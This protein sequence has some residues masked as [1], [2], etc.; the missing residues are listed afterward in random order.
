MIT[1][2]ARDAS[3]WSVVM[4]SKTFRNTRL[5]FV[6][7]VATYGVAQSRLD[8]PEVPPPATSAT[9]SPASTLAEPNNRAAPDL[10]LGSG[11]LVDVN[12]YGMPDFKTEVRINSAGQITLPML[13]A[14]A[15]GG[16]SV[17]K[18]EAMIAQQLKQK[19]LFNDPH[20]TILVKDYATQGIT[21]LGEVQ[22]PGIYPLLGPRSLSDAISTAGGTTPKAGREVVITHRNDPQHSVRVTLPSG[23]SDSAQQNTAIR[24]GDTILVSRAG[25]VYVVGDVHLPGGFVME[26]GKDLTVLQAIALAQGTNPN[27]ALNAARLIR[28]TPEGPKEIPLS[29]KKILSAKAPDMPLQADDIVFVPGSAGKSAAKRGAEAILNMATGVAV[30]RIP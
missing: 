21:V 11:D 25:V 12:L 2:S 16:L 17:E 10:I 24:P 20:I 15:V 9:L 13:G 7:L 29:L 30:W 3:H 19:G 27:A 6:A 5:V 28:K 23:G 8:P 14:V 4:K 22:K 1:P 18:A 26:N